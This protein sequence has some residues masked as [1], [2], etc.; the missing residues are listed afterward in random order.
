MLNN[1]S[2]AIPKTIVEA[3][4]LYREHMPNC[5]YI[6]GGTDVMLEKGILHSDVTLVF[7]SRIAEL[8]NI[9]SAGGVTHIGAMATVSDLQE[10]FYNRGVENAVLDGVSEIG[11]PQIRNVATLGGNIC[12]SLPSAD[13]IGPLVVLGAELILT[14]GRN[15]RNVAIE[16]FCIGV[17]K[18]IL[19]EGE[20]LKEVIIREESESRSAYV[21]HGRRK[22]LEIALVGAS[23]CLKINKISNICESIKVAL[24]TA[25]PR[26][27]RAVKTEEF[28][29]G[30][31]LSA[32]NIE[33]A[34]RMAVLSA[35]TRTSFRCTSEYRNA[36]IPEF[37]KRAIY[38]AIGRGGENFV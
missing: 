4:D 16:D 34:A 5:K 11:S 3:A 29:A 30:K 9:Y 6:A 26:H 31:D 14:D 23:C 37:V 32:R 13:S 27:V 17:G 33:E 8:K 12:S 36:V 18:N 28:L 1:A 35:K 2:V 7:L 20:I 10:Y 15:E 21:K 25:A 22:A 19:S 24:T 38:K